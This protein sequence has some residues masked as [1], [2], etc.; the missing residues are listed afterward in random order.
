MTA[1][2]NE[3]PAVAASNMPARQV[4]GYRK[5][6]NMA[7][8][9]G[10]SGN[11]VIYGTTGDD[12]QNGGDGNDSLRGGAGNDDLYGGEGND[13]LQGGTGQDDLYGG[14]GDDT[15]FIEDNLDS[16]FEGANEGMDTVSSSIFEYT[17]GANLEI[18]K[19]REG[20]AATR[21]VGNE[22]NNS[23]QG[24]SNNNVLDG[25][26]G[27]DTVYGY[28]G[29]DFIFAGEGDDLIVGGTG[30]DTISYRFSNAGVT[31]DL[32]IK[33]RAQDTG[34]GGVDG[35]RE[36]ENIEGTDFADTLLGDSGANVITARGGG[37]FIR[38]RAG[39]D[40][41]RGGTGG[42]SFRFEAA[43]AANGVDRIRSFESGDTLLFQSA[44]GYDPNSTFTLG[45][46]VTAAN[47]AQGLGPQF[48]FDEARDALY[49][50]DDGAGGADAI[51][52]AFIDG[53][54]VQS[55]QILVD[56]TPI[57]GMVAS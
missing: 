21:G 35:I 13:A 54:N 9:N 41:L 8:Q 34:A 56:G 18:L 1:S 4:W 44:D 36:I 25:R 5:G 3:D 30:S 53:I 10:T 29:D 22:L 7:E 26:G 47:A 32:S 31:V 17:L 2:T 16:V 43:G 19:L 6:T 42:D 40:D 27:N 11:D 37:D 20:T 39:D 38:G 52:I 48:I 49:Y 23:I 24:N 45:N 15:Y 14:E 46:Q 57:G 12:V 33:N 50:D 55:N 51:L 28:G